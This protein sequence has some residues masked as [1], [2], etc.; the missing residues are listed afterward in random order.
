MSTNRAQLFL[1]AFNDIEQFLR[2]RLKARNSDPFSS[3]VGQ[4][5]QKHLLTARQQD[6]LRDFASLRNAIAH[7]RFYRNGPLPSP[8]RRLSCRFSGCE[9]SC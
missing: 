9:S 1:A 3:L 7:G 8:C 6:A 5:H 2:D 4:A